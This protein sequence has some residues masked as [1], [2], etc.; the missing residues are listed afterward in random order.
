MVLK[1]ICPEMDYTTSREWTKL[2]ILAVSLLGCMS[3]TSDNPRTMA[4][5]RTHVLRLKP[6]ADLLAELQAFVDTNRLEAAWM[7]TCAGSLTDYRYRPANQSLPLAGSGHFEILSLTGTLSS[8]GSHL[9]VC[10][11][12]STGRAFGGH[13]L[14]GCR[15][16]TTA[17]V[18]MQST[19][20]LRF[21][22][23]IDGTTPWKELHIDTVPE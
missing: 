10:L 16:Y 18:V 5:P 2:L 7:V 9:H 17:E 3:C 13:L 1:Y 12:D 23:A 15:V 20:E 8:R 19:D 4:Q 21:R 11:G 14:E 6:G 22:R